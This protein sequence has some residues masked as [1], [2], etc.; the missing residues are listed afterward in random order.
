[1]IPC[2]PGSEASVSAIEALRLAVLDLG[3]R[4]EPSQ[5]RRGSGAPSGAMGGHCEGQL[6]LP[7]P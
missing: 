7:V 4:S 6:T 2:P 3:R 5:P 1:V